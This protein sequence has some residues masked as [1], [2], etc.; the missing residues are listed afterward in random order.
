N[1]Q[2]CV[3][4]NA[5]ALEKLETRVNGLRAAGY[6]HETLL[7]PDELRR[8]LPSLSPHCLGASYAARDGAADPH[9]ALRAFRRSAV[10]AGVTLIEHCGVTAVTSTEHG[11]RVTGDDAREW[12]AGAIVNAAGAWSARIAAMVG[13]DIPLATKS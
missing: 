7:S 2:I 10:E 4:E 3:A 9:R 6:T 12:S 5:A 1:G 11:W 8:M 13:D